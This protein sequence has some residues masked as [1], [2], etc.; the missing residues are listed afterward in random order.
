MYT[1]L[2]A[3]LQ[4]LKFN[5]IEFSPAFAGMTHKW[6]SSGFDPIIEYI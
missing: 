2:R 4:L 6:D 1:A 5:P 3:S